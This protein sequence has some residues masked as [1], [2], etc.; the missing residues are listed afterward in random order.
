MNQI[1]KVLDDP[2]FDLV[3]KRATLLFED[4]C[5]RQELSVIAMD[6]DRYGALE[7]SAYRHDSLNRYFSLFLAFV[8]EEHDRAPIVLECWYTVDDTQRYLRRR[9]FPPRRVSSYYF[10]GA[11][12]PLPEKLME[13][14]HAAAAVEKRE[15][16]EPILLPTYGEWPASAKEPPLQR[17]TP[18][19]HKRSRVAD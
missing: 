18:T 6:I 15:L 1:F 2:S 19:R 12:S 3:R 9:P 10:H 16:V 17:A 4:F 5:K 13:L 14:W 7:W 11:T 8:G